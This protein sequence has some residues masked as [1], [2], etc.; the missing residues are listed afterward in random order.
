MT[1]YELLLKYLLAFSDEPVSFVRTLPDGTQEELEWNKY[2]F[3]DKDKNGAI[4]YKDDF[5]FSTDPAA[6]LTHKSTLNRVLDDS[7]GF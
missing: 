3:L 5:E 6:T 7:C 1:L 2:M 4:Y